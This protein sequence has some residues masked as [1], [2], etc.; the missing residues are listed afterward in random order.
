VKKVLA[1]VRHPSGRSE[2]HLVDIPSVRVQGRAEV[3]TAKDDRRLR[4]DR[5]P[6]QDGPVHRVSPIDLP[7]TRSRRSVSLGVVELEGPNTVAGRIEYLAF[8]GSRGKMKDE[9]EMLISDPA[10]V[11]SCA[12]W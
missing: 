8:D 2:V 6:F 10:H 4:E 9:I 3:S 5:E 7:K 1:D 12:R 11:G